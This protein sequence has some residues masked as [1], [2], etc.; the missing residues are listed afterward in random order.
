MSRKRFIDD[1]AAD[2]YS[3][4]E[5]ADDP[6]GE[7]GEEELTLTSLDEEAIRDIVLECLAEWSTLTAAER[8][9][10]T[11]GAQEK[12]ARFVNAPAQVRDAVPVAVP[13]ESVQS[14]QPQ[15][16]VRGTPVPR[17]LGIRPFRLAPSN[18]S[19]V[20]PTPVASVLPSS[21][22]A[23]METDEKNGAPKESQSAIY[24]L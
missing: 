22:N 6:E 16:L 9:K 24:G 20:R 2:T 19:A 18:A 7:I 10:Y 23:P 1:E 17:T 5:L 12:R 11:E 4:P 14:V 8:L 3:E 21:T 15:P 13:S